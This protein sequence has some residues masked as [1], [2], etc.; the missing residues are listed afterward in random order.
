MR[1]SKIET[2]ETRKRIVETA[3]VAIM[4]KGLSA[5]GI[6]DVM[7]MAGLTQGGFYRHFESK[8]HL[9]A[10]ASEAAFE[11]I[12]EMM[13]K[14]VAGLAPREAIAKIVRVYLY[15]RLSKSQDYLCPLV[16]LG[17]ELPNADDRIK[18]VAN[19]G[20]KRMVGYIAGLLQQLKI[21]NSLDVADALAATLVGAVTVSRLAMSAASEK[22]VLTHAESTVELVLQAAL[23]ARKTK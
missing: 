22:S 10:E 17:S 4:Q 21:E 18:A 19:A 16:H 13:G 6:A 15:Q 14:Q 5:T 23:D 8:E 11:K 7:A 9:A 3:S 1:K 2:A 20:Y 12:F